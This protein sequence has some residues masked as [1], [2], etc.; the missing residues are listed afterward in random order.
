MSAS[1]GGTGGNLDIGGRFLVVRRKLGGE[2][3]DCRVEWEL[4]FSSSLVCGGSVVLVLTGVEE[5]PESG[6]MG[7]RGT[8]AP[9]FGDAA[10][11]LA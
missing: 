3:A 2:G 6:I 8:V 9:T 1:L 10:L 4:E 11:S 7:V 5:V